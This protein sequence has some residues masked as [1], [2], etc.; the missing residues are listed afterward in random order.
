M[1]QFR[2][3]SLKKTTQAVI[4]RNIFGRF[5]LKRKMKQTIPSNVAKSNYR[6]LPR[7]LIEYYTTY[8]SSIYRVFIV[9]YIICLICC[10][11]FNFFSFRKL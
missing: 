3:N 11:V 2:E 6:V 7:A 8:P 5:I 4:L 1:K 9:C 10:L